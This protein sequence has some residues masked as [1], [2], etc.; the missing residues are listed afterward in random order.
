MTPA[1]TSLATRLVSREPIV[2]TWVKTPHPH[3]VEV[4]SH[5]S[6]DVLILDAEH[7]PFDRSSLDLCLL[8]ARASKM[9]VLV[10]PTGNDPSEIL[11][12]LDGGATG[13]LVPH[14]KCASDA[15][16]A[17][18]SSR[19]VPDGRG[20]AG[21]TRAAGYT[22]RTMAEHRAANEYPLVIAQIEDRD[23]LDH[24]DGIMS[25]DGLGGVFVG[26]ADLAVS[27]E[28]ESMDDGVV[29]DAVDNICEAA[30]R[31]GIALGMFLARPEDVGAWVA[32]GASFF[33]LGSDQSFAL[34][35]ASM[36]AEAVR[37]QV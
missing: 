27:L 18:R 5:S 25:A 23:A 15:E 28:A 30:R 6:L 1:D 10:R 17:V 21:S 29:V 24:L 26:R 37:T 13:I 19:Y 2:G 8:A 16:A 11:Q 3:I 31:H 32:K 14:V 33:F 9:P 34:K 12:A 7:A 22:T 36:L 4:L 35:G 20:Y